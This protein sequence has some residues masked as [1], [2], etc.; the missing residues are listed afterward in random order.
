MSKSY[1]HFSEY[2][3]LPRVKP[4]SKLLSQSYHSATYLLESTLLYKY[5]YIQIDAWILF[6]FAVLGFAFLFILCI[7]SL[8]AY[9]SVNY[10]YAVLVEARESTGSLGIGGTD[11]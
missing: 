4:T 2:L 7:G 6:C 9:I 5:F 1:L 8:P 11:G 3:V 10:M